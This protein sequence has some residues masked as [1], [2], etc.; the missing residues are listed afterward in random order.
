MLYKP[1]QVLKVSNLGDGYWWFN[2]HS[3]TNRVTNEMLRERTDKEPIKTQILRRKWRW[4]GH[5][6]RKLASS[7]TQQ[8]LPRKPQDKRKRVAQGTPG[9]GLWNLK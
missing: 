3:W 9:E 5:T 4:I 6:I 2:F 8:A 7:I 1:R